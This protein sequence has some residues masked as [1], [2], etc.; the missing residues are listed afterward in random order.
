VGSG[1]H[2]GGDAPVLK[3]WGLTGAA[4]EANSGV[5]SALNAREEAAYCD[6]D[7]EKPNEVSELDLSSSEIGWEVEEGGGCS[8]REIHF[9]M[10]GADVVQDI[11]MENNWASSHDL[12]NAFNHMVVNEEFV[13][14]LAFSH[15]G[16][17]YAYAAMPFSARHSP[18]IFTRALGY[19]M[20]YI[21]AHWEVRVIAYMDDV[22]YLHQDREYLSSNA[23]DRL[24]P[25]QEVKFLG[26]RWCFPRLSLKKNGSL[27]QWILRTEGKKRVS[28]KKLAALIGCLN[29]LR[30]Q[31]PRASLNL[32]PFHTAL[33]TGVRSNGWKGWGI[34]PRRVIS[35][36]LF[37]WRSVQYNTP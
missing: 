7:R 28:W 33:A 4:A 12:T 36:L 18:R 2:E 23:T 32:R 10:D 1:V 8:R 19:A 31:I 26:W 25:K 30:V 34:V 5:Q 15:R 37:W 21:R 20:A 13:P 14:H 17:Y 9:R 11:A 3:G 35:E 24:L 16:D 29:F 22:L 27:R 6:R